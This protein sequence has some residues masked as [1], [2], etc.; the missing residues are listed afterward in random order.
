LVAWWSLDEL[1]GPTAA[2]KTGQHPGTHVNGPTPSAGQV[3][4]AL[5]FDG[6]N[7][8]VSVPD[9]PSWDLP[10]DFTIELWARWDSPPVG[11]ALVAHDLVPNP[12]K[13]LFIV[14]DHGSGP[15][16]AFHINTPSLGNG[17][18]LTAPFALEIDR[19][20]HL[21]ITRSESTYAFFADGVQIGS[22]I[23]STPIPDSDR[24]LTL[25]MAEGG[26]FMDGA[27][28]EV[29]IYHR[30]L[31]P[32]ELQAIVAAGSAGKCDLEDPDC[33]A[34]GVEDAID[35]CSGWSPDANANQVPD[36][37]EVVSYCTAGVSASGCAAA[38]SVTGV[39]SAT[40]PSGFEV[41]ATS[42]EGAKSG[43]FYFG[44]NGGQAVPWGTGFQCVVPPVKRSPLQPEVGTAGACDG[45]LS[46]DLNALWCASCPKP[47]HNPGVGTVFQ[48]QAWYRDPWNTATTKSTT[49]SD[50][51][52]LTV[53]P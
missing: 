36:E 32:E 43:L 46:V 52:E 7:D 6:L 24:D 10:G 19:W 42:V 2:E 5:T 22:V 41:T 20:H 25:G 53:G 15:T 31:T 28:D 21:A 48:I 14:L 27:L 50:A 38:L 18:W 45:M 12:N 1:S 11:T 3:Q 39:P 51:L 26:N 34:N 9:S 16:L 37:C 40:A 17:I 29:A 23:E 49:L 47:G 44:V 30:A 35:V 33:N 8:Y 13:W 4:G